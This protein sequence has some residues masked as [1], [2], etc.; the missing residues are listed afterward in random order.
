MYVVF[1]HVIKVYGWLKVKPHVFLTL[2][3]NGGVWSALRTGH[4]VVSETA[5]SPHYIGVWVD[6]ETVWTSQRRKI[7]VAPAG[8]GTNSSIVKSV[9]QPL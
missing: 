1:V 8:N 3:L 4:F 6:R 5:E 2:T 9:K 7:H